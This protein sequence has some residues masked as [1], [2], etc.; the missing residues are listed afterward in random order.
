MEKNNFSSSVLS[1][2][3][4]LRDWK[5]DKLCKCLPA[6]CVLSQLHAAVAPKGSILLTP[7]QYCSRGASLGQDSR[8]QEGYQP[9]TL[10]TRPLTLL[11]LLGEHEHVAQHGMYTNTVRWCTWSWTVWETEHCLQEGSWAAAA[12][13]H[14]LREAPFWSHGV[15][16]CGAC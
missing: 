8:E 3:E 10:E 4:M 13:V 6:P 1:M 15:G 16:G 2:L 5:R 12:P 7:W 9:D 11:T 14:W